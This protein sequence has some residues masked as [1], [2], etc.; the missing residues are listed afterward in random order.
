[1]R[2]FKKEPE[3]NLCMSVTISWPTVD[4]N[5]QLAW[6]WY[7]PV[8]ETERSNNFLDVGATVVG[9]HPASSALMR[10]SCI[11]PLT[12]CIIE[13]ASPCIVRPLS[14]ESVRTRGFA[15]QMVFDVIGDLLADRRQLE[16]LVLHERIVGRP[17]IGNLPRSHDTG[18]VTLHIGSDIDAERDLLMRDLREAGMVQTFFQISG[19]GP[20]LL[21]RNGEGEPYYTDGEIDVAS[22]VVDGVK[23]TEPPEILPPPGADCP[24]G[25]NLARSQ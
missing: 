10:K 9:H 3:N 5:A 1:M 12:S 22:L 4:C 16:Q 17:C 23:R 19:A 20:T 18:Q 8:S 14:S 21:G 25:S 7:Q 2:R 24:K 6:L 11:H 15:C 13:M